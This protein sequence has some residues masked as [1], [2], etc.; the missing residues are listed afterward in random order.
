MTDL[1]K[2]LQIKPGKHWLFFNAP[3]NYLTFIEP[4]P[5]GVKFSLEPEGEFDGA[6]LFVKNTAELIS[7]LKIIM[8]V[9]QPDSVFWISYPKKSSGIQSDLEMMGSWDELGKY[10]YRCVAS[11]AVN[12]T[13]TALRFKLLEKT[14]VSESNKANIRQNEYGNYIDVDNRQVILPEDAA[15]A[16]QLISAEAA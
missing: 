16:L 12:E 1:S 5:K 8:P 15:A 11:A 13:W 4:L 2:K 6:Q 14:K 3:D 7:S 9:L 10:N